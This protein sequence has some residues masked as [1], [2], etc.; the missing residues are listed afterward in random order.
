VLLAAA[1]VVTL[2]AWLWLI[3]DSSSPH[4]AHFAVLPAPRHHAVD[5][6]SLAS[7][8][9]MWQAMMVAMMTP[10]VLGWLFT[11]AAL[12]TRDHAARRA[13]G[14]VAGFAA[15]YFVVWLAYGI[16]AGVLQTVLEHAGF[17]ETSGRLP[18]SAGGVVLIA[19]GLLYFTPFSRACLTHC[20][21]P[22]TYFLARWDNAPRRGFSI[23]LTHGAYCVGCCWALMIT[24]FAMGVM[25]MLWMAFLTL[26]M[27]L[28]KLA[29]NGDRVGA[30]AAVAMAIW[31]AALFL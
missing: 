29:P 15:G 10:S 3:R 18:A 27:C 26:L 21:N 17:L 19:A 28:E 25:N 9:V 1:A 20:R 30:I 2:A 6:W 8:V 16:L 22:L 4:S 13:F 7:I 11:F 23:G 31:G 24:G 14:P 12:T 5:F